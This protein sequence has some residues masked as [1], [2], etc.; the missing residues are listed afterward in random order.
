LLA[1]LPL[2][3]QPCIC[4][5]VH[6]NLTE[7]SLFLNSNTTYINVASIVPIPQAFLIK[8]LFGAFAKPKTLRKNNVIPTQ[9]A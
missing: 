1:Y 9:K 2:V 5:A 7:N 8:E 4:R 6:F 3:H